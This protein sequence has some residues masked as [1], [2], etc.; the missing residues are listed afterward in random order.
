MLA[1]FVGY[2]A[3]Y[4]LGF[5][6]GSLLSQPTPTGNACHDALV[7]ELADCPAEVPWSHSSEFAA[8]TCV[9]AAKLHAERCDAG[10]AP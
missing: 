10:V 7:A 4:C 6:I 9:L 8:S 5:M 1:L 2:L 3:I